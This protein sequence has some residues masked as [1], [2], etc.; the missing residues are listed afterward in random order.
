M[1]WL[2]EATFVPVSKVTGQAEVDDIIGAVR[3]TTCL[4]SIMLANNETGVIMV[5]LSLG[6]SMPWA[7]G[8]WV[9]GGVHIFCTSEGLLSSP[10]HVSFLSSLFLFIPPV[11]SLFAFF[12]L[13]LFPSTVNRA[14]VF[15][16]LPAALGDDLTTDCV[17]LFIS[18]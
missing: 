11:F 16:L 1:S 6:F 2:A 5:S 9:H 8:K 7:G 10:S 14:A 3:P 18:C 17:Y 13:L 4:V 15:K 12:F